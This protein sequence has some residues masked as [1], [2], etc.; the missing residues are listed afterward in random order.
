MNH[1]MRIFAW[2]LDRYSQKI[3]NQVLKGTEDS[4]AVEQLQAADIV[5]FDAD[6]VNAHQHWLQLQREYP[7]LTVI[8][9][10][11]MYTDIAGTVFIQKPVDVEQLAKIIKKMSQKRYADAPQTSCPVTRQ[12]LATTIQTQLLNQATDTVELPLG[13]YANDNVPQHNSDKIYYDP[14]HYLQGVL[15]NAWTQSQESLVGDMLIA[16]LHTPMIIN[17]DDNQLLYEHHFQENLFHTMTVLPLARSHVHIRAL[18]S[19]D[20]E[21]LTQH[22]QFVEQPLEA[23]LW[24][25]A[26]WTARGRLPQGSSLTVPVKLKHWPNLTRLLLTPHALE[27]AALWSAHSCSLLETAEILKIN[28]YHV[29]AFFS[30][31]SAINIA[32]IDKTAKS[33]TAC[34]IPSNQ[35]NLFQWLLARLRRL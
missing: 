2:G 22:Y 35:R 1:Q 27:I 26:L 6:H 34:A 15:H 29:F 20:R 11:L 28:H 19:E 5:I 9:V 13:C 30:A 14:E 7:Q 24:K 4:I 32:Y 33:K 17:A 23:M 8:I 21:Q 18:T 10:A 25:V 16:G 31:T 12:P 3:L